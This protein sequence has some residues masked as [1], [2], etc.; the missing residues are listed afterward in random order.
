MS[1]PLDGQHALITGASR[2]IGA[3]IA[4]A[5]ARAGANVTLLGRSM[6][7]LEKT[8][9]SLTGVRTSCIVAD[10][11]NAASVAE[12]FK[13]ARA[14]LGEVSILVN[15]AGQAGSAPVHKTSDEL[16]STMLAVNLTGTFHCL[17]EAI[18]SMVKAK[19][20]RV[21]NIASTAALTGY[22]YTAAYCASKHGV[23]GL[24]RALALEVA[25]HDI[26]VNAVCPG[27]TETDIL[28]ETI[29]NICT[30]TGRTAE[31]AR[32]QLLAGN[33]QRRFVQPAEVAAT[34]VWLCS[35][36]SESMTGQAIAV[37][38]GEVLA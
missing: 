23:L 37:C 5:L 13:R 20:G 16:W 30:T 11:S 34:V 24:T 36:G 10:V 9:G 2:G 18:P 19:Y 31:E 3:E 32:A 22:R 33:P 21:I 17:R 29:S 8:A 28:E 27:F 15:N 38:G 7:S 25:A 14:A 26:T 1:S 12:G 4:R 35:P 6:P